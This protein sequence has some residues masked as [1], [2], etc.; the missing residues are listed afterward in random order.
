MIT[1]AQAEALLT[2]AESLEACER[3]GICAS[4]GLKGECFVNYGYAGCLD[5]QIARFDGKSIRNA[6]NALIPQKD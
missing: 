6:V 5:L 2:L 1:R 4:T 3:V